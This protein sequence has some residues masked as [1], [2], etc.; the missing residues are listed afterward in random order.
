M[1]TSPG[2]TCSARNNR[3]TPGSRRVHRTT[4][5]NSRSCVLD[6]PEFSVGFSR[7]TSLTTDSSAPRSQSLAAE[8]GTA[9]NS[10]GRGGTRE[11][12]CSEWSWRQTTDTSGSTWQ[13]LPCRNSTIEG[14]MTGLGLVCDQ[15]SMCVGSSRGASDLS[16]CASPPIRAS[17]AAAGPTSIWPP[18]AACCRP[19]QAIL[20]LSP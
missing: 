14:S 16:A 10:A 5:V 3:S 7:A 4:A 17:S 9:R 15:A 20:A 12:A 18:S 11:I 2:S 13:F 1:S 19:S 6:R 8:I